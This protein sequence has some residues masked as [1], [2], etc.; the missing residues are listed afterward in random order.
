VSP[1]RIL[2]GLSD[3]DFALLEPHLEPV[4]LPVKKRHVRPI[5]GLADRASLRALLQRTPTRS[6]GTR[7]YRVSGWKVCAQD[8]LTE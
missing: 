6:V 5:G 3:E 1:N 2:A 8:A 7:M 4:D